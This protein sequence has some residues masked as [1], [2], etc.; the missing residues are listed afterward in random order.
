MYP[1]YFDGAGPAVSPW[2]SAADYK[3]PTVFD[4]RSTSWITP[5]SRSLSTTPVHLSAASAGSV[6][7]SPQASLYINRYSSPTSG[8]MSRCDV[9]ESPLTSYGCMTSSLGN[10]PALSSSS[11]GVGQCTDV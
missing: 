6:Y 3:P 1:T 7:P 2:L 9:I 11:T 8:L 10:P 5:L 4:D